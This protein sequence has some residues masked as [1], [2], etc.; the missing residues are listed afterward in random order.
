[1]YS[2]TLAPFFLG[3]LAKLRTAAISF[4]MY[5]YPSIRLEKFG[6]LWTDINEI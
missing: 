4:V 2:I 5:V 3:A 1:M 6:S